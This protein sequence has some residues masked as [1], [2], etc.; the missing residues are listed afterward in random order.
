MSC[1]LEAC[2]YRRAAAMLFM[3]CCPVPHVFLF[4]YLLTTCTCPLVLALF[5]SKV[6]TTSSR[7]FGPLL[8]TSS[9]SMVSEASQSVFCEYFGHSTLRWKI[10]PKEM[11]DL[12][13]QYETKSDDSSMLLKK[14]RR[15]DSL[16]KDLLGK[17]RYLET[18]EKDSSSTST[19]TSSTST[20]SD[21]DSHAKIKD[22]TSYQDTSKGDADAKD[23][24]TEAEATTNTNTNPRGFGKHDKRRLKRISRSP[25]RYPA[26]RIE[27]GPFEFILDISKRDLESGQD[28]GGT[29]FRRVLAK[30]IGKAID[31]K[32]LGYEVRCV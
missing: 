5:R 24:E 2:I 31:A 13:Q 23:T 12:I 10:C 8:H 26:N 30:G 18:E 16:Y 7:D 6:I 19:S 32:K 20:T 22:N 3:L 14:E 29:V 17:V 9:A 11:R 21:S 25:L 1:H 27:V 28:G 4:A 15:N